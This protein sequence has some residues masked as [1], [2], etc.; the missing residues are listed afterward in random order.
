MNL[1]H[2]A[3]NIGFEL[4]EFLE[5]VDLFLETTDAD[6]KNLKAAIQQ[7]DAKSVA[8]SAHSIKGAAGNMGFQEIYDL[9]K[10]IE[11]DAREK[12]LGQAL[13]HTDAIY[14]ELKNLKQALEQSRG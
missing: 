14:G 7:Q 4:D 11:M 9:A 3:E 12:Q 8:A 6:V 10:N 2:L 13:A 1:Q 5:L